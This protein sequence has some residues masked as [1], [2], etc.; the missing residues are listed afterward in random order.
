MLASGVKRLL[1]RHDVDLDQSALDAAALAALAPLDGPYLPWTDFA[2]RPSAL[3]VVLNDIAIRDC[4]RIV[5]LGG[6]ISSVYIGRLLRERDGGRL[7]TV[8]HDPSWTEV[9][10]GLLAR[11]GLDRVEIVEAPLRDGWYDRVE[12]EPLLAEPIDLLLVDGPPAHEHAIRTAR[13]PAVPFFRR[14][15]ADD[16]LVVLDDAT[17]PGEESILREWERML[18]VRAQRREAAGIALL[19]PPGDHY[20]PF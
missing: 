6:G 9:L 15:F 16:W 3:V 14:A 13:R 10:H 4:Q 18:G 1:G 12:L 8:E 7:V 5:E 17:R 11:E 2:L 20:A 19:R